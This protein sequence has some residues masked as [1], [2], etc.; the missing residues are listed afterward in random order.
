MKAK[1]LSEKSM[2][3]MST[4][5]SGIFFSQK[6]P[7][8]VPIMMPP[9]AHSMASAPSMAVLWLRFPE[10]ISD[11]SLHLFRFPQQRQSSPS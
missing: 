9:V 1:P 5:I 3:R 4:K 8:L 11:L 6:L 10:N 7:Q 2:K